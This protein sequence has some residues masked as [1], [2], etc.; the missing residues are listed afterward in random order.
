MFEIA[1]N[2]SP[3]ACLHHRA[4][5]AHDRDNTEAAASS[6]VAAALWWQDHACFLARAALLAQPGP[7][8]GFCCRT[9]SARRCGRP[10]YT[11][12]W[13]TLQHRQGPVLVAPRSMQGTAKDSA[14]GDGRRLRSEERTGNW[15]LHTI[16]TGTDRNTVAGGTAAAIQ[17]CGATWL[18]NHSWPWT[19]QG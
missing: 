1:V 13:H 9:M 7:H 12:A 10:F 3:G 6:C 14:H 2:I 16:Q 19:K 18:L 8:Y 5:A 11:P 4:A 17:P 15:A